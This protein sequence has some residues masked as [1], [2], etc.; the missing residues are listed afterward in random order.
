MIELRKINEENFE[1]CMS[2]EPKEE[3][4][5]FVASNLKSL[6]EAYIALANDSCIPMP[7]AI[8]NDNTMVGFLMLSFKAEDNTKDE[9]QYWL[10]RLM[11]D[12]NHQRKGYGKE[13]IL[14][15]LEL[16][17]EFSFNKKAAVYLSYEP[18]N[19]IARKLYSSL[20]FQETGEIEEGEIVAKLNI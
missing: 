6:A 9:N 14:K 11:I 7:Y 12:K 17:K 3:Q 1:E 13:S 18:E 16:I 19:N 15:V 20:G 4:K 2:L 5:G 8:Y 10:C